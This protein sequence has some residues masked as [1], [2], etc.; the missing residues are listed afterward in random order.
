MAAPRRPEETSGTGERDLIFFARRYL[1]AARQ[2]NLH[3]TKKKTLVPRCPLRR[4]SR[5]PGSISIIRDLFVFRDR[6]SPPEE[7]ISLI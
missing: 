7:A 4:R 2:C 3:S 6:A 1:T 5:D